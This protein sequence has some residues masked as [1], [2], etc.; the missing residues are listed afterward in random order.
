MKAGQT[1][2]HPSQIIGHLHTSDPMG[3]EWRRFQDYY[4]KGGLRRV[5]L[6]EV[7]DWP[8]HLNVPDKALTLKHVV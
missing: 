1:M 7:S 8:Q 4:L 2:D 3:L 6:V 5:V